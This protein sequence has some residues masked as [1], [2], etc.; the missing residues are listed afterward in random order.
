MASAA[1]IQEELNLLYAL[2]NFVLTWVY[3]TYGKSPAQLSLTPP[4]VMASEVPPELTIY[5]DEK[6]RCSKLA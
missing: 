2:L 5:F 1:L 6:V 4:N 3:T